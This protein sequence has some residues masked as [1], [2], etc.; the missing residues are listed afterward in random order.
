[1]K[2]GI[3]ITGVSYEDGSIYRYRDFE[4]SL[5]SFNQY[6]VK[7]LL[8]EGHQIFFYIYTYDSPKR[9]KV[10]NSYNPII[11]A[12]FIDQNKQI[13]RPL[14][15][16]QTHNLVSSL[17][18]MLDEDLDVVIRARFDMLFYKSPFTEYS[19]KW[20]KV[21]FLWKEPE[22][23][24]LPLV[25]DTFFTFPYRKLGDIISTLMNSETSPFDGIKIGMHN[26]YRS[27]LQF[28]SEEDI[29]ILDDSYK[30]LSENTLYKLTRH[31]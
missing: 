16:V 24:H 7:P 25:N 6:I 27:M 2:I 10:L 14:F 17:Q 12:K 31:G 1:M 23:H 29:N 5:P 15:H 13:L 4:E 26:I 22:Y 19:F 11:K 8:E 18:M 9:M 30:T 21:N 28:M 20:D 3:N